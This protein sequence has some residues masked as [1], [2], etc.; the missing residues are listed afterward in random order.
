[1]VTFRVHAPRADSVFVKGIEELDR[2]AMM[3]GPQGVWSV[4]VG[5]LPPEL[6]SYVFEVDGADVVDR[7]NRD[8]KSWF[9]LESLVEIPGDPPLIH[10]QQA[11]P[12]GSVTHHLYYSQSAG[13]ERG[14]YVYTPPGYDRDREEAYPT[15][16]LLHGFGDDEGA[17]PGV[18]RANLIADNL[19][20]RGQIVPMVIVMPYGHPEPLESRFTDDYRRRNEDGMVRD[21]MEDLLPFI[22]KRYNVS[23]DG[24]NR[25]VAGLSMGGGQSIRIGLGNLDSFAWIGAFS[26]AAPVENLD[27]TLGS[28]TKDIEQTN[29][30]IELLW[31]ACGRDDYLID[32]NEIFRSWLDE[33]GIVNTYR[34]TDGAHTWFVWREYLAQFLQSI[35]R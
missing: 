8:L 35:F 29:E 16:F 33:H 4:T 24:V 30:D 12:H 27:E 18:G 19:L 17:W 9:F 7:H 34:L 32:R 23:S 3:R 13:H 11:V 5:P 2:T 25:A 15:L 1:S 6:Y 31:I 21:V 20:D 22:E 28:L 26:A 10:E 14:V